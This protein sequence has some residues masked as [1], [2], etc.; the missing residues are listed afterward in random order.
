[1]RGQNDVEVKRGQEVSAA[2]ESQA[3]VKWCEFKR[4]TVSFLRLRV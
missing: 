1:M 2:S 4:L 3:D